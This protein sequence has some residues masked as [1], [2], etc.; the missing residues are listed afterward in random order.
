MQFETNSVATRSL[1]LVLFCMSAGCHSNDP[2]SAAKKKALKEEQVVQ[3]CS[4]CHQPPDPLSFPQ[5]RWIH[6]VYKGYRFD[7]EANPK[8]QP[9]PP[10]AK[11]A[12]EYYTSRAPKELPP[13]TPIS[14]ASES[15]PRFVFSAEWTPPTKTIAMTA[16][17]SWSQWT[18]G[19][20]PQILAADMSDGSVSAWNVSN[21]TSVVLGTFKHPAHLEWTDLDG[22][23]LQDCL[24][25]DLGSTD[26]KDHSQGTVGWLHQQQ[27]GSFR[28]LL[29]SSNFGRV[30]EVRV[31]DMLG[32]DRLDVI[33]AEFGFQ[34]TGGIHILERHGPAAGIPQFR[35][36]IID[37]RNGAMR[38]PPLDM[39]GDGRVDFVALIAQEHE[40]IDV[41]FNEGHGHFKPQP[42]TPAREPAFGSNGLVPSDIDGDGDIDFVISNGDM[43]DSYTIKPYHQ[44]RWLENQGHNVMVEHQLIHMPGVHGASIGDIDLDGDL[45]ILTS[46]CF[47][48]RTY[49]ELSDAAR[50]NTPSAVWL[51][52]TKPGVFA[53]H[54]V[55]F[56]NPFHACHALADIDGDGDLDVILGTFAGDPN[57][58]QHAFIVFEN[59]TV[60]GDTRP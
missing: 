15:Q 2:A 3:F 60:S 36:H 40:A 7:V 33:V 25:A 4:K 9:Q 41:F 23:G 29:L 44:L 24:V 39:N 35:K 22:D 55:E 8:G 21:K 11:L 28:Q 6:E 42:L 57:Q 32:D 10:D 45:D 5:E 18:S 14:F 16:F 56:G 31:A 27:D 48:Y 46:A 20:A 43:F 53:P 26:A 50:Q 13:P 37:R 30:S 47:P 54:P 49:A 59:K 12:V 52:Q 38:V 58:P 34:K 17:V 1:I 19:G 51:E